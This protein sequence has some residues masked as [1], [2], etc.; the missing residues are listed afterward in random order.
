MPRPPAS[1]TSLRIAD[2]AW[3]R[4]RRWRRAARTGSAR[5]RRR[6]AYLAAC[7]ARE[8]AEHEEKEA[9]L[10]REQARLEE[11]AASQRRTAGLQ[12]RATWTLAAMVVAVVAGLGTVWYLNEINNRQQA[13]LE[14]GRSHLERF[15]AEL[16]D[17][18][19]ESR[20]RQEAIER[21]R[22]DL[23]HAEDKLR[24]EQAASQRRQAQIDRGQVN[25]FAELATSERLRGNLDSALRLAVQAG[26]LDLALT[27]GSENGSLA[28]SALAAAVWDSHWRWCLA[29]HDRRCRGRGSSARTG[30]GSSPH[31][32]RHRP[33]LGCRQ[34]PRSSQSCAGRWPVYSASFSA[35]GARIVTIAANRERSAQQ[36]GMRSSGEQIAELRHDG[37]AHRRDFEPRRDPHCHGV[38]SDRTARIW[39]ARSGREIGRPARP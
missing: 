5:S 34:R 18:Q 13:A 7:Q 27:T 1:P 10:A 22:I 19:A 35:D 4:R 12:R 21:A 11:V 14:Q 3:R 17:E 24:D 25:L 23:A 6:A 29:G 38:A 9:T 8:A 36:S 28:R 31:R 2:R 30:R 15:K 16:R 39:D 32:R 20:R 26:R 33:G 37:G